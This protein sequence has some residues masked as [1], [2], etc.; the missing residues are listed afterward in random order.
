MN[1]NLAKN[2]IHIFTSFTNGKQE[3]YIDVST[4]SNPTQCPW[5]E[6]RPSTYGQGLF[7]KEDI[8][9]DSI[10]T[11]YPMHQIGTRVQGNEWVIQSHPNATGIYKDYS[12]C[13]NDDLRI[14]GDPSLTSNS[15]FLGHMINDPAIDISEPDTMKFVVRYLISCKL[16]GN[17]SFHRFEDPWVGIRA[18]RDI[19]KGEEILVPYSLPYWAERRNE[20]MEDIDA[21]IKHYIETQPI[22]KAK[23]LLELMEELSKVFI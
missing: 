19:N 13:V 4:E 15:M 23:F 11:L 18:V 17:A 20:K 22:K 14:Y 9:K 3:G 7:A 16:R 12:L 5:L 1:T 10:I 2:T 6:I 8:K 21:F